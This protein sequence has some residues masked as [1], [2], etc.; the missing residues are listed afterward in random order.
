MKNIYPIKKICMADLHM[1]KVLLSSKGFYRSPMV[2]HLVTGIKKVV[3]K[4]FSLI[5]V[6]PPF[7]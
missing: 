7:I 3:E 5:N 2:K 4:L 1:K 6:S